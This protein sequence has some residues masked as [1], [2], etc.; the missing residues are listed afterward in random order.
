MPTTVQALIIIALL[1][2]G[3]VITRFLPFIFFPNA[4]SAPRYVYYLGKVLPTAAISLLVVYCLRY[5]EFTTAPHGIPEAFSIIIV[6]ALHIWKK[7]TLISIAVGTLI[8]M[9]LVQFV[10]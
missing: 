4:A 1:A 3:T 6:A 10:F 2:F 9:I 5:I 7:N 8:Y